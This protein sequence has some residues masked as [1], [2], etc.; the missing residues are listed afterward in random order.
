ML[1]NQWDPSAAPDA[2]MLFTDENL[3]PRL[4]SSLCHSLVHHQP[5]CLF[6][7]CGAEPQTPSLPSELAA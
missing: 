4:S 5:P 1:M 7:G 3:S 6:A 2:R